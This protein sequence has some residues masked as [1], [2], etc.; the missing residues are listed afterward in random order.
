[1]ARIL[2]INT[3]CN[4][5]TG[6]ICKSL[7][8]LA[9]NEGHE[10]CIAY[11]RG[12]SPLEYKT[13]KIG[14][15]FDVYKHAALARVFDNS[16]FDSRNATLKFIKEVEKFSPNII[17][18]HNIHGYYIN[19]NI[20]FDYLRKHPEIKKIWTLH[21][22]WAYTGR[23]SHYLYSNCYKWQEKCTK[24]EH[25]DVYPTTYFDHSEKNFMLKKH[26][27]TKIENMTIVCVSQ[28]LKEE[29]ERS[30]LNKYDIRK[31]TSGI[32]LEI[33]QHRESDFRQ[34]YGL[35]N[36][37]IILGVAQTWTERKGLDDFIELSKMLSDEYK[38]ILI[39]LSEQQIKQMPNG[40]IGLGRTKNQ[41]ELAEIYSVADV[42]FNPTKE[43]TFGLTNIEAQACDT[44]VCSYEAG[45]TKETIINENAYLV[46]DIR[47]FKQILEATS[48]Q[49]V[50]EHNEVRNE[51]EEKRKFLK[52]LELYNEIL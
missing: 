34:K 44:M 28:W 43:E 30:F 49:I 12:D 1:M 50:C 36:K 48:T 39:G 38:I 41:M 46:K 2:F 14:T 10:C 29:V 9:E 45:G 47:S 16:G 24:C 42:F 32:N 7:Y 27:F 40:I 23:C 26:I 19:V 37:K 4:G 5:S 15:S 52:Y 35:Q 33:F 17:H 3:V 20:L 31:I 18:M 25:L 11:G 22:C 51:F 21:D 6:N 13:I 8:K